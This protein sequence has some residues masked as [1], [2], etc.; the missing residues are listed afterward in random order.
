MADERIEVPRGDHLR[1]GLER[2]DGGLIT[3]E[4]FR[5]IVFVGGFSYADVL[6]FTH[7]NITGLLQYP[8]ER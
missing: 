3:L 2:R 6:E 7:V 4:G 1:G 8:P 5:G